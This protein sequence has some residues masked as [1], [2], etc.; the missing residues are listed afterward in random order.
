MVSTGRI[1]NNSHTLIRSLSIGVSIGLGMRTWVMRN[2]S[3][4]IRILIT[5]R[6]SIRISIRII[7]RIRHRFSR[8]VRIRMLGRVGIISRRCRWIIL[9]FLCGFVFSVIFV[10]VLVCCVWGIK[11]RLVLIVCTRTYNRVC[12]YIV[13]YVRSHYTY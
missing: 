8:R 4:I 13:M 3:S 5:M 6:V 2:L 9:L 1:I 7:I 12:L 11:S 10:I